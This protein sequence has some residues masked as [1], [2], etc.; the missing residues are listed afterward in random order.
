MKK[1]FLT[2]CFLSCILY[3]LPAVMQFYLDNTVKL[4]KHKDFD[5][6]FLGNLNFS[7]EERIKKKNNCF[8]SLRYNGMSLVVK[9]FKQQ[10]KKYWF[11]S[12]FFLITQLQIMWVFFSPELCKNAVCC[13][14]F[15][16]CR[17]SFIKVLSEL[18][19]KITKPKKNPKQN[20]NPQ[21]QQYIYFHNHITRSTAF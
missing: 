13:R 19:K 5:N 12:P 20:P 11:I 6:Q 16:G 21:Q 10:L 17:V 9:P 3:Y 7:S 14:E 15:R 2:L 4:R 8:I 1:P 18:K